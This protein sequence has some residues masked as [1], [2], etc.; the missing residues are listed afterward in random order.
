MYKRQVLIGVGGSNNATR[1]VEQ[2]LASRGGVEVV[3]AGNT[4]SAYEVNR[5]LR[6]LEGREV[7]LD[8]VA[9]NFETLEPVSYTHLGAKIPLQKMGDSDEVFRAMA[10]MMADC[11]KENNAAGS[12]TVFICPV[13]PVGQYPFFVRRVNEE[14]ISLKNVWFFNMDE[15]LEDVY[16][17]QSPSSR[18]RSCSTAACC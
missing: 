2:A 18:S 6:R 10:D 14:R 3:Y 12:R 5:L 1:A 8:C 9:K 16:K 7:C 13:G 15:Y 11:I 4:L 17:R